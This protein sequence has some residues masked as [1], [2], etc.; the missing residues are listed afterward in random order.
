MW[1]L[2]ILVEIFEYI[3]IIYTIRIYSNIFSETEYYSYLYS[4]ETAETNIIH[5]RIRWKKNIRHNTAKY[6]SWER[7][8]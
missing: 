7:G 8:G 1:K 2:L 6:M 4:S 5:I 3:R